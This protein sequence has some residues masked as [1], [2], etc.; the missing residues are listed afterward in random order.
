MPKDPNYYDRVLGGLQR[1]SE[2]SRLETDPE[3]AVSHFTRITREALGDPDG[4]SRPGALK[5]GETQ[6][7]SSCVFFIAPKRDHMVMC[8]DHGFPPEQRHAQISVTDS[9]PGHTVQTKTPAVVPNTDEDKIFRQI[10]ASGRVGCS[11][12][13][14]VMW[15]GE[16]I[17]M[18][19]TACKARYMFDETDMRMQ[20]LYA[21]LAGATWM[22][23]GGP[24][25]LANLV[26]K[27]K[28][29]APA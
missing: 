26:A 20:M 11:I 3:K 21:N 7:S 29:W 15:Q 19:N 14:P 25:Y 1:A 17:G 6:F 18:F 5:P 8:A 22:A 13:V 9:R 23:L 27:L 10:L 2:L 12:Y 24:A 4:P 28:P 16:V